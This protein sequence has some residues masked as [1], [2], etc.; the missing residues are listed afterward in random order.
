ML[1]RIAAIP[2]QA[3]VTLLI[4]REFLINL[5]PAELRTLSI[6][7]SFQ[8]IASCL[9]LGSEVEIGRLIKSRLINKREAKFVSKIAIIGGISFLGV[10]LTLMSNSDKFSSLVNFSFL[11]LVIFL[12]SLGCLAPSTTLQTILNISKKSVWVSLAPILGTLLMGLLAVLVF[13][14]ARITYLWAY[15]IVCLPPVVGN[16][17]MYLVIETNAGIFESQAS[18]SVKFLSMLNFPALSL[19][20]LIPLSIG[21]ERFIFSIWGTH[22]DLVTVTAVNRIT[23]PVLLIFVYG[24]NSLWADI[25][26]SLTFKRGVYEFRSYLIFSAAICALCPVLLPFFVKYITNQVSNLSQLTNFLIGVNLLCFSIFM[27]IVTFAKAN[28]GLSYLTVLLLVFAIF[29][30]LIGRFFVSNLGI[31]AYYLGQIVCFISVI[32]VPWYLWENNI[33]KTRK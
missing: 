24:S 29:N 1:I 12:F 10:F 7:L 3:C 30:L 17:I 2:I 4:W 15:C 19:N 5:T 13:S 8:F 22:P 14:N 9:T 31:N 18:S 27:M 6:F 21:I 32:F 25:S 20:I 16:L 26:K 33:F 28:G 23:A 11:N